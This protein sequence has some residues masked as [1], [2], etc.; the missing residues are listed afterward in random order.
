MNKPSKKLLTCLVVIIVVLLGSILKIVFKPSTGIK[1]EV[2]SRV[3]GNPE[4][5]VKIVEFADFQCPACANGAKLIKELFQKYPDSIR[6]EMK[7][8]PLLNIHKNTFLA[9][10]YAECAA[11]QGSFWAYH[12][13]LFERQKIWSE[14]IDPKD[15]FEQFARE[16]KL[17]PNQ[18]KACLG[19]KSVD[20]LITKFKGE[21]NLAG[22]K[23]TPTYFVNGQMIV[24]SKT[25][26]DEIIKRIPS[27][28]QTKP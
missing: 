21:G 10:H 22:V 11:R 7:Y 16:L 25:I 26:Q 3:K 2:G 9:T 28:K 23:S 14:M 18:L 1:A 12:D 27:P 5:P 15:A 17:D 8:F 20:V 13:L 6:L 24:G 19:D 4:A